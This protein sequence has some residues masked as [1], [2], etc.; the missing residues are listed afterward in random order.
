MATKHLDAIVSRV[1][2]HVFPALEESVWG[3]RDVNGQV[4]RR[5]GSIFMGADEGLRNERR[6]I[7]NC[8][9]SKSRTMCFF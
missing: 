1:G 9:A 3:W 6:S 8:V 4:L 5:H 7:P 2:D